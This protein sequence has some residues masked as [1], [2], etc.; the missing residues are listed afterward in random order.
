M[1]RCDGCE[2]EYDGLCTAL[3]EECKDIMFCTV[4]TNK[5]KEE[6]SKTPTI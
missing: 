2:Y 6:I 5:V 1:G 4:I 3:G